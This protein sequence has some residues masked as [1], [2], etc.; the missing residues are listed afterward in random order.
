MLLKFPRGSTSG[1]EGAKTT[2]TANKAKTGILYH[3]RGIISSYIAQTTVK[4]NADRQTDRQ[5][6]NN[7]TKLLFCAIMER[8]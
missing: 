8:D 6:E 1:K 2:R 5:N 7:Y 4:R 3:D